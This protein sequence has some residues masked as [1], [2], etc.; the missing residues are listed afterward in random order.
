MAKRHEWPFP[1]PMTRLH[2]VLSDFFSNPILNVAT[3]TYATP[4]T[5]AEKL[6]TLNRA[7]GIAVTLPAAIGSGDKYRFV[8]G[9]SVTSNSTTFTKKSG[10]SDTFVGQIETSTTTGATTNGFCESLG[11]ADVTITMNGSTTGGLI[12]SYYEFEDIASAVWRVSGANLGSGSL[13]TSVS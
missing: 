13:A 4:S 8:I 3:S 11:G 1:I 2:T 6:I 12:G 5:A 10:S 9:T 7:A